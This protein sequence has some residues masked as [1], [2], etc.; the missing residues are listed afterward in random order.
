M[1]LHV[2]LDGPGDRAAR[3]YLTLREAVVAGRLAAG[4]RVPATR[5]L[6]RQ[7]G[8]ARGTVTVAYDRLVAEGFLETRPGA[9]TFVTTVAL[10]PD[11]TRRARPGAVRPLALWDRERPPSPPR[12]RR[13]ARPLDRSPGPRALPPRGLA[14]AGLGSAP[15]V[16]ARGGDLQRTGLLAVAGRDRPLPRAVALRR[17]DGGRRRRHGRC[18]AG[19]RP[20]LP[21]AGGAR[22][23]RGRGGPW[24]PRDAPAVRDAPRRRARRTGRRRGSRRRRPPAGRPPRVRDAVAPV[25]DRRRDVPAPP[26]RAAAVGRRARRRRRRGRLRQR[27]PLVRPA[28]RAAPEP[29]PRRPRRLRRH[30]LQVAPARAP[31]RVPRRHHAPCRPRCARRSG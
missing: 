12:A 26:G 3:I 31:D 21:G 30:L 23:R 19:G 28:R 14:P 1:E 16:A 20:R 27:V 5:D 10:A 13:A 2:S 25:P 17:R 22:L 4:D 9:G 18:A 6:A 29:R 7:L 11:E 15:P 8:V 24:L